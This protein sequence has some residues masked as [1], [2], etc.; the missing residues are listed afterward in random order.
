MKEYVVESGCEGMTLIRFLQRRLPGA[1][2]SLLYKQLRKKNIKLIGHRAAGPEKL[3]QNDT[4]QV[5]FS[6][7]TLEKFEN[8]ADNGPVLK[9]EPDPVRV[10]YEDEDIVALDKEP[11][12][13][14]QQD[15]PGQITLNE[16][17]IAYLVGNGR[18]TR[19]AMQLVRPSVGNRLDRNTSGI[20]LCGKTMRGLQFLSEAIRDKTVKKEYCCIVKGSFDLPGLHKGFITKDRKYNISKVSAEPLGEASQDIATYYEP[21]RSV[22]LYLP[23][24]ADEDGAEYGSWTERKPGRPASMKDLEP[25]EL[26]LVR[27]VLHTGRSHQIRAQ[28]SFL[29]YPIAG[30]IKYGDRALNKRLEGLGVHRQL[31][32]ARRITLPDGRMIESPLP[33][34]F[35]GLLCGQKLL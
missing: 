11:G 34:D 18:V 1:A 35:R 30:D 7:E 8:A 24:T 21:D 20:V 14:C 2:G 15:R 31:L 27:A 16:S 33:E 32:H 12:E 5:W 3:R 4:V 10:L 28:L 9:K 29:G 6:D 17:L 25:V 22:V 26:S 19:E 13:L 23:K